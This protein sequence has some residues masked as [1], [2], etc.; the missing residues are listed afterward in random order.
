MSTL[1][2]VSRMGDHSEFLAT[3]S[4]PRIQYVFQTKR[5]PSNPQTPMA[6]CRALHQ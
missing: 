6:S 3:K 4:L 2:C 1:S 5:P